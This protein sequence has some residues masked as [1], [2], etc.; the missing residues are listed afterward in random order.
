MQEAFLVD[1]SRRQFGE[2]MAGEIAALYARYFDIPYHQG[3]GNTGDNHLHSAMERPD[4]RA[5]QFAATHRPYLN[6]LAAAA[7]P[8]RTRVP[9]ARQGFYQ[10]HMLTPIAIHRHSLAMLEAYAAA[11]AALAA[12]DREEALRQAELAMSAVDALFAAL[13]RAETGRWSSWYMGDLLVGMETSRDRIRD[14]QARL[15]GEPPPPRRR[16][17]HP[18]EAYPHI[19]RYQLPFLRNFPRLY[20]HPAGAAPAPAPDEG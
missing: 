4:A 20:P 8:L 10:A 13:R 3:R 18:R 9:A 7:E 11:Q 16:L 2:P 14:L 19:Y 5:R 1:W 6:D 12:E 17:N 15:R